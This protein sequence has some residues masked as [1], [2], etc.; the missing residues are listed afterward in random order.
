MKY[1]TSPATSFSGYQDFSTVPSTGTITFDIKVDGGSSKSVSVTWSNVA[2]GA[3]NNHEFAYQLNQV[4]SNGYGAYAE[5]DPKTNRVT[6]R[7][8]QTGTSSS[9]AITNL[10]RNGGNNNAGAV[11]TAVAGAGVAWVEKTIDD[12]SAGQFVAMKTDSKGG[13]HFAYYDTGNGDL[14]YAYMSSVTATPVVVT[15]DGYQQVGQYVDLA[16]KETT[17]GTT[18]SV[19]PYIGYYSMSN[20]DTK[21]AAKVAKLVSPIVYTTANGTV[22]VNSSSVKAGSEDELFT[23]NW[24]A[25]H[26]PTNGIP[27]QYRVNIGV[28]SDGNV[29]I[30]YLADRIIEYVKVE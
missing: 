11:N 27:V 20:A 2:T 22:S 5:V 28:T 19:T 16:L 14:K 4:L 13:I 12:D 6:V 8:M 21:R 17:S 3:R 26:I 23:G 7:S 24:E 30:G 29:Y 9:I 10:K 1:N 25:M 18:T 15:V